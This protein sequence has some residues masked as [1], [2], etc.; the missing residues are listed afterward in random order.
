MASSADDVVFDLSPLGLSN[1]VATL[2]LS[3]GIV[4]LHDTGNPTTVYDST[5]VPFGSL[6]VK[7]GA[8]D[9]SLTI[10]TLDPFAAH[11]IVEARRTG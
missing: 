6:T 7:L 4:T 11:L 2:T 10:H 9:D 8:G 1:D 3:A 5:A